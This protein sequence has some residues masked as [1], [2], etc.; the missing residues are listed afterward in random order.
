MRDIIIIHSHILILYSST[1]LCP[2]RRFIY[3]VLGQWFNQSF[4]AVVNYTNRNAKSDVTGRQIAVAYVGATSGAV[5]AAAGMNLLV[6]VQAICKLWL[7]GAKCKRSVY[8][9]FRLVD[10]KKK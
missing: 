2:S 4:N 6:E 1:H 10:L 9:N 8:G 7:S 5:A 3:V